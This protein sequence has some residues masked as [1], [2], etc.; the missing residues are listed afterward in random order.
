M[1]VETDNRVVEC[2]DMASDAARK[3]EAAVSPQEAQFWLRMERRWLRLAQTYS[4]TEQLIAAWRRAPTGQ[5][6]ASH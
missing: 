2:L 5:T 4:D 6:R 1:S 3:A